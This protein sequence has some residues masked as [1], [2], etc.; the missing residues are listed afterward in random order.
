MVRVVR[1]ILL[2]HTVTVN[3]RYNGS[4]IRALRGAYSN[5]GVT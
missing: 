1:A 4:V 5:E 2:V 3:W